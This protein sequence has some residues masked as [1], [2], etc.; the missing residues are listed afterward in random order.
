MTSVQLLLK[1]QV[2]KGCEF[3]EEARKIPQ[4]WEEAGAEQILERNQ[5]WGREAGSV[6]LWL[7]AAAYPP[8]GARHWVTMAVMH[9][10]SLLRGGRFKATLLFLIAATS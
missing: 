3:L 8:A 10:P 6:C 7:E 2:T 5:R 1:I 9:C 4:G